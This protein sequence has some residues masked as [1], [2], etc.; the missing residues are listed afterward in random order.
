MKTLHVHIGTPKTG[1]SSLQRFCVKNEETLHGLGYDYPLMPFT[2]PFVREFRNGH[3]LMGSVEAGNKKAYAE[4][5]A[6]NL[7]CGLEVLEEAFATYDNVVLSEESLYT[8]VAVNNDL[9]FCEVLTQHAR[10]HGYALHVI[11]YLRRPDSFA[12]SLHN[13]YVKQCSPLV[14]LQDVLAQTSR[15]DYFQALERIAAHVGRENITVR[16]YDRGIWER[17]GGSIYGDFLSCIGLAMS[18]AF[19]IPLRDANSSSL[20]GNLLAIKDAVN[21]LPGHTRELDEPFRRAGIRYTAHYP[22]EVTRFGEL[23]AAQRRAFLAQFKESYRKVAR[24]YLHSDEPLFSDIIEDDAEPWH[25]DNPW[26]ASDIAEYFRRVKNRQDYL[27][28]A[29]DAGD[30]VEGDAED[31]GTDAAQDAPPEEYVPA[32]PL[33]EEE[34]EVQHAVFVEQ[35]QAFL[36]YCDALTG[37]PEGAYERAIYYL[38]MFFL[39]RQQRIAS[40][41]DVAPIGRVTY[42][43]MAQA[44]FERCGLVMEAAELGYEKLQWRQNCMD[45][46]EKR[47]YDLQKQ[48]DAA[49]TV[50]GACRGLAR[51]VVRVL[52]RVAARIVHRS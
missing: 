41:Q 7:A 11:V 6:R 16:V 43:C 2:F 15:F 4:S 47:A 19:F 9:R 18:D 1:T 26:M 46:F 34:L 49:R 20:P 31:A 12:L 3:F 27:V 5:D 30:E 28:A 17:D 35:M 8:R 51:S 14:S 33:S 45:V 37:L 44:V 38:G 50:G 32:G 24:V 48:V 52:R 13:Q 23:S 39:Q 29:R 40:G 10:Q 25:I 36:E 21:K 22:A 42:V